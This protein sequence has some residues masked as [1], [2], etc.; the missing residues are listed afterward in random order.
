MYGTVRT[1]V[2]EDGVRKN[3]SYPI[4]LLLQYILPGL[5]PISGAG[6]IPDMIRILEV[7]IL[8]ITGGSQEYSSILAYGLPPPDRLGSGLLASTNGQFS[9]LPRPHGAWGASGVL[10]R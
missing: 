7:L 3:P 5:T 10:S 1:V 8:R 6:K 2:W 9:R 4:L